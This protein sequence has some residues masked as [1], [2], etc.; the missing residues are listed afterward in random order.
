LEA[1]NDPATAN[2][3]CGKQCLMSG[4]KEAADAGNEKAIRFYKEIQ[5]K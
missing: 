4:I 3:P 2:F 5:H 1:Y